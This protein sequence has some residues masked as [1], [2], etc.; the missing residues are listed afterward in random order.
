MFLYPTKN[1][2]PKSWSAALSWWEGVT[3]RDEQR[4]TGIY[5]KSI[6]FHRAT[7][8][9]KVIPAAQ[10]KEAGTYS[11]QQQYRKMLDAYDHFGDNGKVINSYCIGEGNGKW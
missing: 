2:F 9:V 1:S 4:M 7:P 8:D 11:G 3:G 10:L 6:N 5:T